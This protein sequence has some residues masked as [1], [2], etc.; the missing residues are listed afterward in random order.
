[1]AGAEDLFKYERNPATGAL[2]P[3][4]WAAG[5]GSSAQTDSLCGLRTSN[6]RPVKTPRRGREGRAAGALV[7]MAVGDA[8]GAPLEFLPFIPAG[9]R[10]CLDRD[11]GCPL[12]DALVA[13]PFKLKPGQW[14][15]DAAMGLCL[16][17]GGGGGGVVSLFAGR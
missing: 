13:N 14:T 1:M 7:G 4:W 2:L 10:G 12:P 17:S 15:D 11:T 6:P 8:I 5:S 9:L 16:V 3:G